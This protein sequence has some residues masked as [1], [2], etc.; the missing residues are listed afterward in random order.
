MTF[1]KKKKPTPKISLL[2]QFL[3][4][5]LVQM[6]LLCYGKHASKCMNSSLSYLPFNITIETYS[7]S[8][9]LPSSSNVQ[10]KC[11]AGDFNGT[12]IHLAGPQNKPYFQ[13]SSAAPVKEEARALT[14][15]SLYYYDY[16]QR[17]SRKKICLSHCQLRFLVFIVNT[18]FESSG[19]R[20]KTDKELQPRMLMSELCALNPL[21]GR[22]RCKVT[23]LWDMAEFTEEKYDRFLVV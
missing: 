2:K 21:L 19:R 9:T 13:K 6:N 10:Q 4:F 7:I 14:D 5:H 16:E 18:Q 20:K 12:K 15:L 3:N 1:E 22:A 17:S 11:N 23:S 8:L